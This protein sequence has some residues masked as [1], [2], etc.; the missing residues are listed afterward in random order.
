MK[1]PKQKNT[2][3][4]MV[5][6][7]KP[8]IRRMRIFSVP[9]H[10]RE[11]ENRKET[12]QNAVTETAEE[13]GRFLLKNAVYTRKTTGRVSKEALEEFKK[14]RTEKSKAAESPQ[15]SVPSRPPSAPSEEEETPSPQE[16]GAR[17]SPKEKPP[18]VVKKIALP[19]KEA[20]PEKEP[21]QRTKKQSSERSSFRPLFRKR[22]VF[23]TFLNA[24]IPSDSGSSFKSGHKSSFLLP[25]CAAI[26]LIVLCGFEL[27][28]SVTGSSF[29]IFFSD[30]SGGGSLSGVIASVES[31]YESEIERTVTSYEQDPQYTSVRVTYRGDTD[32]D[33]VRVNNWN[34]VLAVYSVYATTR[35]E[36]PTDVITVTDENTALLKEIFYRM[37]SVSFEPSVETHSVREGHMNENGETEFQIREEKELTLYVEQHSLSAKECARLLGFSEQQTE[38]LSEMCSPQYDI[39]Y[40]RIAGV[41]LYDGADLTELVSHLPSS[42]KGAEVIKAALTKLGAPYVMGAKGSTRFDCSG[43]AYWSVSQVDPDLGR[44]LYTNAAGQARYCYRNNRTVAREEL[45]PGDLVF[46]QNLRCSGCSRWNE[47][48][49]VGIYMGEGKVIEA[50]SS[51]GRVVIRKLWSSKNYPIFMFGRPYS[52]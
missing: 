23:C 44:I 40:A 43:L 48:H 45:E 3:Q 11:P 7:K 35:E 18:A 10:I 37:N 29:G 34:D 20:Q 31:A 19:K 5:P 52:D 4:N 2:D 30:E 6:G 12:L 33:S 15:N 27:F 51:K 17:K 1:E 28:C 41:D 26:L 22:T 32:G 16:R 46:W 39:Y 47:V 25:V 50:S 42:S 14:S 24:D 38:L 13:S 36:N 8:Q 49:H 21:K 9:P